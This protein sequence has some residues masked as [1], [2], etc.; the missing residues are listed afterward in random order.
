MIIHFIFSFIEILSLFRKLF[1]SVRCL[2][3]I[4]F[5][6]I[7]SKYSEI[8]L[9]VY[10]VIHSILSNNTIF[11]SIIIKLTHTQYLGVPFFTFLYNKLVF[12]IHEYLTEMILMSN[13]PL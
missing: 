8:P 10:T 2:R 4:S 7:I 5:K 13:D 12:Y 9:L 6:M 1:N 3:E 11:I